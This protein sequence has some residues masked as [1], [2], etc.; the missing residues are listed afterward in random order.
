MEKNAPPGDPF[1]GSWRLLG[2]A[3]HGGAT[4]QRYMSSETNV[5]ST[6]DTAWKDRSRAYFVVTGLRHPTEYDAFA[7]QTILWTACRAFICV[8]YPCSRRFVVTVR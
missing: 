3:N 6:A 1:Y 7:L 2:G 8:W 5:T 4:P